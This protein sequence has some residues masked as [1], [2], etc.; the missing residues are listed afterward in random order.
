M[1]ILIYELQILVVISQLKSSVVTPRLRQ[2]G[3][4]IRW[5]IGDFGGVLESLDEI[6]PFGAFRLAKFGSVE[7]P[8]QRSYLITISDSPSAFLFI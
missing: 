1:Q 5:I 8:I 7:A 4:C 3:R 6:D 2:L